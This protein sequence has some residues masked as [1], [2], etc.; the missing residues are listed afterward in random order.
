MLKLMAKLRA[1]Q[2]KKNQKGF[3]LVELIVVVAILG[4][5]AVIGITRFAGLTDNARNKADIATAASLASAAQVWIADQA[6]APSKAPTI[7]E[8]KTANLID[9]P[10]A[11]QTKGGTWTIVYDKTS[12]EL[13][14]LDANKGNIWYPS[15]DAT[16]L[17]A[18]NAKNAN[19]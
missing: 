1:K 4:I 3:T 8:L 17:T 11:P 19:K 2:L 14:V 9:A 18:I 16:E 6:T 5:L 7:D 15:P 10:K 13:K 12:K